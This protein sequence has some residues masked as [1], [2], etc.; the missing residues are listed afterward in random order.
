MTVSGTSVPTRRMDFESS[1]A[2]VPRHFAD[3]GDLILSH[4]TSALSAVFPD[5]EDFFVRSVRRFRD[6]VTDPDLRRQVNGFIGQEA[7]HGREHRA[8][9]ERLDQLGYPAKRVERIV[10]VGLA[11]RERFLSP[12]ANLA[13]TAALEH[14]TATLAELVLSDEEV[15]RLFG[16]EPVRDLFVWH[17]LEECEHKSVAFDVYRAVG[18]SE[19]TRVLTMRIL[20]WGFLIG[21]T[22]QVLIGLACDR[23]TY[24]PGRLRASWRRF[25]QSPFLTRA[26]WDRLCD[27]D[28]PDFHP[29][30]HDTTELVE[31]WRETLFGPE[32]TLLDRLA[33]A[34]AGA[35]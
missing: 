16:A 17:A 25:R 27:Y 30:D 35:G 33:G 26:L 28:R 11:I 23:R 8:F 3:D 19:R 24:R 13:A 5:G 29:L 22:L 31:T 18:G 7:V 14:F 2:G 32:G 12:K 6:Q 4:L 1:F 9:N 34:G 15:R 10:R 20:R 21:I